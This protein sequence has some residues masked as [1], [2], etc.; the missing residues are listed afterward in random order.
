MPS[1]DQSELAEIESFALH[2]DAQRN[3]GD[4]L[5]PTGATR[6][7]DNLTATAGVVQAASGPRGLTRR[8]ADR[9]EEK[10]MDLAAL[11]RPL[12]DSN[13]IHPMQPILRVRHAPAPTTA[14]RPPAAR[15]GWGVGGFISFAVLVSLIAAIFA[16]TLGPGGNFAF[17]QDSTPAPDTGEPTTGL[18]RVDSGRSGAYTDPGPSGVPALQWLARDTSR[19]PVAMQPIAGDAELFLVDPAD[20]ELRAV[21]RDGQAHGSVEVDLIQSYVIDGGW[22]YIATGK[23]NQGALSAFSQD[24]LVEAWRVETGLSAAALGFDGDRIYL[25][26]TDGVLRAFDRSDGSESW[27]VDLGVGAVSTIFQPP[28]FVMNDPSPAVRGGLVVVAT[29]AGDVRAFS[30]EDGKP[31]W[32]FDSPEDL[33]GAPTIVDGTIYVAARLTGDFGSPGAGHVY[34]LDG[35]TGEQRWGHALT[36]WTARI[37]KASGVNPVDVLVLTVD[38]TNVYLNGDGENG[39]AIVALDAETGQV[40]WT[41]GFGV[42][43]GAAPVVSGDTLYLTRPDGGVYGLNT[44]TGEQRW[45][46]DAGTANLRS[47]AILDDLLLV[48]TS[49]GTVIGLGDR[50]DTGDAEASPVAA[51]SSDDISGLPPCV[52]TRLQP[53]PLPTGE[54]A[55]TLDIVERPDDRGQ[56]SAVRADVPTDP[57]ADADALLGI[58]DTLR[59]MQACDRPGREREL[60]GFFTD[61]YYRRMALYYPDTDLLGLPWVARVPYSLEMTTLKDLPAPVVLEDGRVAL[62]LGW[63]EVSG[64]DAAEWGEGQLVIFVQTDG[65]WLIDEVVRVTEVPNQPM[66]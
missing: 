46:L 53:D 29:P 33:V 9:L 57:L 31:R 44:A 51:A 38:G 3:A 18:L 52:A 11:D 10:L 60:G 40:V 17:W 36:A 14:D 47:P 66:G 61:D 58:V 64:P 50:D 15:H 65:V 7:P 21:D 59:A 56:G 27:N 13:G 37:S 12:A 41:V 54:P 20:G 4:A 22:V 1:R 35:E 25:V 42:A 34:A 32:T 30:A 26:D 45:R 6:V 23:E 28:S 43:S 2:L 39:D 24:G 62:L 49:Q 19:S 16:Q 5:R 55:R 63:R 48:T 8:F